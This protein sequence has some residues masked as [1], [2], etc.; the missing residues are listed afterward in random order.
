[1]KKLLKSIKN[2]WSIILITGITAMLI[3]AVAYIVG[4]EINNWEY[5]VTHHIEI[6]VT[7]YISHIL[8]ALIL[9]SV[10]GY[11]IFLVGTQW[12]YTFKKSR[13]MY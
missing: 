2:D 9:I 12:W 1:M 5:M 4:V 13:L 8:I 3:P 11:L 7:Y 10:I 6:G